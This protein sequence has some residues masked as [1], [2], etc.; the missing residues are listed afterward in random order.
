MFDVINHKF[1]MKIQGS[2]LR[3]AISDRLSR[4]KEQRVEVVEAVT[5]PATSIDG[6]VASVFSGVASPMEEAELSERHLMLKLVA[7]NLVDDQMYTV[8]LVDLF[9]L[10]S[11]RPAV[12]SIV[13]DSIRPLLAMLIPP[14]ASEH[15]P[16]S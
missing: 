13:F 6:I 4:E 12:A 15:T 10:T 9:E 7:E 1:E 2:A 8:T 14:R 3:V 5:S 11:A 16:V